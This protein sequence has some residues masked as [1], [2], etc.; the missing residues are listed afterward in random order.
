MPQQLCPHSALPARLSWSA[1]SRACQHAMLPRLCRHGAL[2]GPQPR[3]GCGASC[4]GASRRA[5]GR[6]GAGARERQPR[7]A[8]KP[9]ACASTMA[10]IAR[11][12]TGCG[13]L[14]R[15]Q[16]PC[17]LCSVVFR[18]CFRGFFCALRRGAAAE[19]R[20]QARQGAIHTTDTGQQTAFYSVEFSVR[21]WPRCSFRLLRVLGVERKC[22]R[23][24][25]PCC[26]PVW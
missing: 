23:C 6:V 13:L 24:F 10:C 18:L 21:A 25:G 3:W 15:P 1:A 26:P 22:L 12:P 11:R 8:R 9:G 19:E 4:P 2:P 20:V 14:K 17:W 7:R 16:C 5:A